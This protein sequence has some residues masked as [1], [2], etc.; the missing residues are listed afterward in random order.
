M[1]VRTWH[2]N[3]SLRVTVGCAMRSLQLEPGHNARQRL[4]ERHLTRVKASPPSP[5]PQPASVARR[6]DGADPIRG[7]TF[8][9][10]WRMNRAGRDECSSDASSDSTRPCAA[11]ATRHA[12]NAIYRSR[13]PVLP[14]LRSSSSGARRARALS[15]SRSLALSLRSSSDPPCRDARARCDLGAERGVDVG[16]LEADVPAAE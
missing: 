2:R 11:R 5:P 7:Q 10:G 14:A 4:D 12:R 1:Y 8:I 9:A 3:H 16:E 15:L 13:S 6:R